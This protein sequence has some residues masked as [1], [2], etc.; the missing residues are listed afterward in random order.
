MSCLSVPKL[1]LP[2]LSA[3]LPAIP[4]IPI[5]LPGVTLPCCTLPPLPIPGL[6]IIIPLGSALAL[7][8][9]AAVAT[10]LTPIEQA[11]SQLNLLLDEIPPVNCPLE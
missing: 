1:P 6:P 9:A 4:D 2:D 3:L 5:P 10:V 8:G 7:L 11:V